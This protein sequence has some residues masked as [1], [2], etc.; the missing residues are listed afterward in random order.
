MKPGI[1][2]PRAHRW[3]DKSNAAGVQLDGGLRM[4]GLIGVHA[5]Q[6]AQ[7]VS[8]VGKLRK[9]FA[10]IQPALAGAAKFP[11]RGEQCAAK[12]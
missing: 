4:G 9:Q 2:H 6:H 10:D 5:V 1:K 12:Q 11:R 3:P 8:V 7:I